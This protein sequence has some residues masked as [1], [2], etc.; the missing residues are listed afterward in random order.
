MV[1]FSFILA[2]F[3]H[4][5][6]TAKS[7]SLHAI[8]LFIPTSAATQYDKF[9]HARIGDYLDQGGILMIE[10]FQDL[11]QS[12]VKITYWSNKNKLSLVTLVP[13]EMAF[14]CLVVW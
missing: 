4:K 11:L 12:T 10:C 8:L 7:Q 2:T 13:I 1:Y 14:V 5:N 3:D 6:W 9:P